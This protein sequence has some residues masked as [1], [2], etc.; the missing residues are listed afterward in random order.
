M[1]TK[2]LSD[3]DIEI[4]PIL[5]DINIQFRRV[6]ERL[7]RLVELTSNLETTINTHII[8]FN[9]ETK[10]VHSRIDRLEKKLNKF[11]DIMES[12]TGNEFAEIIE[13]EG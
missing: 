5:A 3:F 10:R 13:K 1:S 6:H 7:D 9:S 12:I 8:L 4:T 2:N 11:I